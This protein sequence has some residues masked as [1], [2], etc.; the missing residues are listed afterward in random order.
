MLFAYGPYQDLRTLDEMRFWKQQEEEHIDVIKELVKDLEPQFVEALDA[1]KESFTLV[2]NRITRDIETYIR[3]NGK[4]T[5]A[6]HQHVME[7]ARFSLEQS[8]RFLQF[9]HQ[10]RTTS[11]AIKGKPTLLTV[12]DHIAR[13]SEYFIG[14]LQVLK[15]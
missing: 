10:M 8:E 3:M 2:L 11:K 9:L 5:P 15:Q 12:I 13:E 14:V 6:M 1:W 7:M 4:S